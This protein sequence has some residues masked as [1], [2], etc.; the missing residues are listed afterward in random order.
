[1]ATDEE[2]AGSPAVPPKEG[3]PA[4]GSPP[5]E[6]PVPAPPEAP[7]AQDWAVRFKYLFA[8]FENF[9]RRSERDREKAR[10]EGRVAVLR[11][12]LPLLET[13]ERA[14]EAARSLPPKH[15]LRTGLDLL[16]KEWEALRKAEQLETVARVGYPFRSD[17]Q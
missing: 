10:Q 15:P 4:A 6:T 11:R 8:D 13:S 12:L 9:R 17:E 7:P 16:D 3:A 2:R 5:A 14:A 1:M